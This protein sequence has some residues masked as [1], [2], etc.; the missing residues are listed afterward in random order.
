VS[1]RSARLTA[2][3]WDTDLVIEE[4]ELPAPTGSEIR[5]AVEAC[6][7]CHRDVIDRDGRFPFIRIPVTP[8]HEA[9]GTVTAVGPEVTDFRVGDRVGTMHRDFCG[10]CRA[11][12]SGSPSQCELGA[13]AFGLTIDGGYASELVAPERCFYS[14]P[15]DMP[16]AEAAILH[17]TF[18]TAYRALTQAGGVGASALVTGANGGVGSAAVQVA[19]RMGL[20]VVAI[21]RD[22]KH[23]AF[24]TATGA[25]QVVVDDG[26][27]FHKKIGDTV[28]VALECVGP[29]TF[30]A[31]LRSVR[32]GGTVVVIGNV[33]TE[34]PALNLG[35]IVTRGIAIRGSAG[36]TRQDMKQLLAL[37]A[38]SPLS[39]CIQ[40]RMP[41]ERADEAQRR[42]RSGGLSGRLVLDL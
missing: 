9:A 6:G 14:L 42:V 32:S 21:V 20:R 4:R 28:D 10:E 37:H 8:G 24:V 26:S 1:V 38:K 39:V 15:R 36:A 30:N 7:V 22:S 27:S 31:A 13:A 11:C 25:D 3:G 29:P 16:A 2:V 12:A 5:V 18:G 35:Y 23:E 40:E 33:A 19:K 41:L 34:R 17:C